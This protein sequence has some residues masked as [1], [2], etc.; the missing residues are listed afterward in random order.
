MIF[1]IADRGGNLKLVK[2]MRRFGFIFLLIL[3]YTLAACGDGSAPAESVPAPS[4][5]PAVDPVFREFYNR[6]GGFEVIGPAISE[7][8]PYQDLQCQFTA[9]ALMVYDP[10]AGGDKR[11]Y[12]APIGLQ[13]NI[14][15]PAAPPP[16]SSGVKY[17]EGHIIYDKFVPLYTQLGGML[18]TGKPLTEL[19]YN[20]IKR[21]YEQ[22]FENMGFYILE[23]DPSETVRLLSYG[24]WMCDFNC[25]TINPD[26]GRIIISARIDPDFIDAVNRLGAHLTGFAVSD[27]RF[28]PD[29]YKE[30]VFENIALISDKNQPGRVFL[31]S[32]TEKLGYLPQP[33]AAPRHDP[34]MYFYQI[35]A[36][37]KG[38]NVPMVFM[39]YM[40]QHGGQEQFGLPIEEYGLWKENIYRQ[41]FQNVCLE[42]HLDGPESL[43][44]RPSPLGYYYKEMPVQAVF[45]SAPIQTMTNATQPS[46]ATGAQPS[47]QIGANQAIPSTDAQPTSITSQGAA[48]QISIQV[49]ETF[50]ML[51]SG[52][53]QEIG[54]LVYQDNLP[55]KG[56]EPDIQVTLPDGITRNYFMYPTGE[57][58]QTRLTLEPIEAPNG[59]LI[60]YQVCSYFL[61]GEQL[62]VRDTFTIW[63][64]Q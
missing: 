26:N 42:Q 58:G 55:L 16:Q 40:A 45:P 64:N 56:V 39:D 36:E 51:V 8:F 12:L 20:P 5:Y 43:R 4:D 35:Q 13:M 62:C 53:S 15:E 25:R 3:S 17:I 34:G 48:G 24:A 47:P 19:H 50:P 61:G 33:L 60:P 31:R 46:S 29:G 27:V 54:V 52:E 21:R 38:H 23:D 7:K 11:F 6:L 22:Y 28:T 30:Q 57:D 49:W 37:D 32:I 18:T 1:L 63:N 44:I 2:D 14:A 10:R 9:A 59:T 41:C